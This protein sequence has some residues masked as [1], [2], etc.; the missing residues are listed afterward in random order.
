MP[1]TW[2]SSSR[3]LLFL[4]REL[5][6]VLLSSAS[7]KVQ[8]GNVMRKISEKELQHRILT[9]LEVETDEFEDKVSKSSIQ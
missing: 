8:T 6:I 2:L 7:Y 4:V 3:T 1:L 5:F 9:E